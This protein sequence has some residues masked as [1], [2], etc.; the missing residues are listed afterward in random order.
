MSHAT[1]NS[2]A[3]LVSFCEE[4]SRADR[5]GISRLPV[6]G[7][8]GIPAV[9]VDCMSA[10]IG[11]GRSTWETGLIRHMNAPAAA[12]GA[13]RGMSVREFARAVSGISR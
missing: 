5:I 9:A 6:L 11:D 4:L 10:R 12:L 2:P 3:Q 1:I 13:T 8:R 7:A